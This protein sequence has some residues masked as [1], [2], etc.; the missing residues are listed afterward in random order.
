MLPGSGLDEKFNKR[1]SPLGMTAKA[2][3]KPCLTSISN[4]LVL[5]LSSVVIR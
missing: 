2:S 5:E 1:H 3:I 4:S